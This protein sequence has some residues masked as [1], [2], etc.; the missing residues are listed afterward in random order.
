[1]VINVNYRDCL[2]QIAEE[3]EISIE[4]IERKFEP[5]FWKAMKYFCEDLGASQQK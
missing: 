3:F 5:Y 4:K 2:K 1:M